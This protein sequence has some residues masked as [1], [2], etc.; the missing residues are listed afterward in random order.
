LAGP[1]GGAS[2][3]GPEPSPRS[4]ERNSGL[5]FFG[6]HRVWGRWEVER[7]FRFVTGTLHL[8]SAIFW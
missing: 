5:D 6:G 3:R 8:T 7:K 2:V 1:T 4:S